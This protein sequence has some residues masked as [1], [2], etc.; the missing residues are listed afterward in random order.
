MSQAQLIFIAGDLHGDWVRLN[1][2]IDAEI[3]QSR[4]IR[5]LVR[6]FDSLEIIIL[7][8]GDFGYWPH[9][10]GVSGDFYERSCGGATS[11][12]ACPASWTAA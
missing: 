2:F 10:H 3:R 8:T 5:E 4:R 12:T 1:H 9:N 6:D 7:Q 11:G